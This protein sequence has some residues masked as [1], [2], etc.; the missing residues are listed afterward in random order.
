MWIINNYEEACT[1]FGSVHTGT[2][3]SW[4]RAD[5]LRNIF[6]RFIPIRS[7]HSYETATKLLSLGMIA[8]LLRKLEGRTSF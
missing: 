6:Q 1:A 2:P 4:Y 3:G 7:T 8:A 5:K